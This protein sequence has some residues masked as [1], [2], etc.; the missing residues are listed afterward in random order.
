MRRL[1]IASLVMLVA[2]GTSTAIE[3]SCGAC[4][5]NCGRKNAKYRSSYLRAPFTYHDR[6]GKCE[7]R[8][9]GDCQSGGIFIGVPGR[10]GN[11]NVRWYWQSRFDP[12]YYAAL[13]LNNQS[14]SGWLMPDIRAGDVYVDGVR[15]TR[16]QEEPNPWRVFVREWYPIGCAALRPAE[17]R[18]RACRE[19]LKNLRK[20]ALLVDS[21][22]CDLENER[23]YVEAQNLCEEMF[24]ERRPVSS[25]SIGP[26]LKFPVR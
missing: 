21:I 15:I 22:S 11:F 17:C 18:H 9:C 26:E 6:V 16:T 13:L 12:D 20:C 10:N 23:R 14:T 19:F 5:E 1:V 24:P 2:A 8:E 25:P 7:E 3:L 4:R